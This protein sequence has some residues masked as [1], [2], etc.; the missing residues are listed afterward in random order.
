VIAAAVLA[1]YANAL[2]AGFQ[3]DDWNVIVDEPRVGGLAAWWAAMPGIRPLLKLSYALN[4]AAGRGA[5]GFHAVNVAIHL[6]NSWLVFVLF[7]R[8][9]RT[10]KGA[11]P[12][13]TNGA[14]HRLAALAGA[15]VFA[16]HPAQTEAVTYV[17]GRSNAL[18]ALL[19]LASIL[20]WCGGGARGAGRALL[21]AAALLAP[22]LFA[23]ALLV[24]ETAAVVPIALLLLAVTFFPTRGA[25]SILPHVVVLGAAAIAALASPTY[26]RLFAT[27]IEARG[28]GAN[29]L[30]QAHGVVYLM[31]QMVRPGRLNADPMLAVLEAWTPR[32][33]LEAAIVAA[34]LAL[35]VASIRRRPALALGILWFFA[36][37]LPTNSFLPRL[38]VVNDRQLYMALVG[39]AWLLACAV[40]R[41][42]AKRG[43]VAAFAPALVLAVAL[44]AA[45]HARN[46]VYADEIVFWEDVT[47]K[48]PHNGRAFNNL[49]YA[50]ALA[51]R[52]D[53]AEAAF[54]G[55][56]ALDPNDVRAAVDLRLLREGAL[57]RDRPRPGTGPGRGPA[58]GASPSA[59]YR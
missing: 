29:L 55:A 45:T 41:G 43:P 18:M 32:L 57:A 25:R 34:L 12:Q 10:A 3:F 39:P 13:A 42:A 35:G 50:L 44:G 28:I 16:L 37:L 40:G 2:G 59:P 46:R 26:R 11:A 5:A 30:T 47:R 14:A 23:A 52:N 53:E 54:I 36:W 22:A 51:S 24:K 8:A 49:G 17:S 9:A 1:A 38:D 56:L 20:A 27:S 48:S 7:A 4:N 58:P 15:L 19:A 6:A 21:F 31:G 33:A